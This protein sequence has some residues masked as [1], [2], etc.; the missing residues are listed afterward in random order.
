MCI[1]LNNIT[2]IIARNLTF[3]LTTVYHVKYNLKCI[4]KYDCLKRTVG[5]SSTTSY[6]SVKSL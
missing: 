4:V 1:I 6:S 3:S 5:Y 2:F